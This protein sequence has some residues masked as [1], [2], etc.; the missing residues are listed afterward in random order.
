[1]EGS[2]QY[3]IFFGKRAFFFSL[4]FRLL[5]NFFTKQSVTQSILCNANT[6]IDF[7]FIHQ[8]FQNSFVHTAKRLWTT[9]DYT[10][11]C[12]FYICSEEICGR[13]D[14]TYSSHSQGSPQERQEWG[15]ATETVLTLIIWKVHV[16]EPPFNSAFLILNG[17]EKQD[18]LIWI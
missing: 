5:R 2:S 7:Q 11:C 18:H 1:M 12:L 15:L 4:L 6:C 3:K 17:K 9:H 13:V 14:F 8:I 16:R 10:N